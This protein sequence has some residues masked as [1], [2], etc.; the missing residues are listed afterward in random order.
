MRRARCV[1]GLQVFHSLRLRRVTAEGIVDLLPRLQ[2][3]A[4]VGYR[5]LL[6]LQFAQ[7][8]DAAA[9]AL[10]EEGQA[11][12]RT[13][14]PGAAAPISNGSGADRTRCRHARPCGCS[15]TSQPGQRRCWRWRGA[16]ALRR[17]GCP[18]GGA[19]APKADPAARSG[20]LVGGPPQAPAVPTPARPDVHPGAGQSD[21]QLGALLRQ[22]R[23][24]LRLQSRQLAAPGVQVQ[25]VATPAR[26]RASSRP[27]RC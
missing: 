17:H 26:T 15:G 10:V 9:P 25:M 22:Q 4:L 12:A 27:S 19:R 21:W 20:S 5:G 3:R 6:L 7:L 13:D 23:R 16:G 18:D 2:H 11:D 1:P 14:G 24:Q 8:H